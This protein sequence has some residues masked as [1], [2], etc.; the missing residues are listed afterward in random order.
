MI[1]AGLVGNKDLEIKEEFLVLRCGLHSLPAAAL[2]GWGQE[3]VGEVQTSEACIQITT[4]S[5]SLITIGES[6]DKGFN[7]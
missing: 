3:A 1:Q 4:S 2:L 6:Y 7:F 5:S